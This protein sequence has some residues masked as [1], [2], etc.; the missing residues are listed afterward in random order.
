[1]HL[2][3]SAS[4]AATSTVLALIMAGCGS[5]DV[6]DVQA[7]VI[8]GPVSI[9][10]D[11]LPSVAAVRD[12]VDYAIAGTVTAWHP[13][14][15]VMHDDRGNEHAVLELAST[16]VIKTTSAKAE[17]RFVLIRLG[18]YGVDAQG[19]IADGPKTS[20]RTLDDVKKALPLGTRVIALGNRT[21]FEEPGIPQYDPQLGLG[22]EPSEGSVLI[23]PYPQG[24]LLETADGGYDSGLVGPADVAFGTSEGTFEALLRDVKRDASKRPAVQAL[25]MRGGVS[26]DYE[27]LPSVA[28]VRDKVDDAISG[29]VTAWHAGPFVTGG[30]SATDY[31]VLELAST[32]VV[33]SKSKDLEPRFILVNL[34]MYNVNKQGK[35]IE[36]KNGSRYTARTMADV[37][38]A[39]PIGTRVL[40]LGAKT[41]LRGWKPVDGSVLISTHPQG[42]L[43]ETADGSYDSGLVEPSDVMFGQWPRSASYSGSTGEGSFEALLRDVSR[44]S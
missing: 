5:T 40:A 8:R 43:L 22:W 20:A 32:K 7:S 19:K 6:A 1:M 14:P 16:D 41:K 26:I 12:K 38:K 28:A 11:R 44:S 18:Q 13:G 24:L 29:T 31:A 35:I 36:P 17:P 30:G 21:G 39:L 33:K 10:Y 4:A 2:S 27:R 37:K 9:D 42:L 23:S 3:R 34:G 15:K 25:M